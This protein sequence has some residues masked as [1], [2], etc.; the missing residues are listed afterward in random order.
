MTIKNKR[1]RLS[2]GKVTLIDLADIPKGFNIDTWIEN[3]KQTGQL[4]FE[5]ET[6]TKPQYE[7]RKKKNYVKE[8][9]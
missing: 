6:L 5:N 9:L 7:R 8:F 3:F 1:K 2:K 4:V